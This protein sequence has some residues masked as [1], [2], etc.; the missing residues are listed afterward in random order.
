MMARSRSRGS[1]AEPVSAKLIDGKAYARRLRAGYREEVAAFI[2]DTGIAAT[3][4]VI[5]IGN[6]APSQLYVGCGASTMRPAA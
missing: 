4:A 2:A 6:D 5:L 1:S 3:L